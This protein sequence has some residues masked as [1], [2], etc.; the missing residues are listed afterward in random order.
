[1]KTNILIILLVV[2]VILFS[3]VSYIL[4][5]QM[6]V[7][8]IATMDMEVKVAD[9]L[10]LNADTDKIYFGKLVPG[11]SG[12]RKVHINNSADYP[13]KVVIFSKGEIAKW[14]SMSDNNF[15]LEGNEGTQ[16]ILEAEVPEDQPLGVYSGSLVVVFKKLVFD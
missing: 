12:Q 2:I 14:V 11:T 4:Y 15:I 10:G 3:S 7:D 9:N 6:I 5:D 16:I 13:L 8:Q 1:M